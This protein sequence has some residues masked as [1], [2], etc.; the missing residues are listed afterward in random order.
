MGSILKRLSPVA[1]TGVGSLPF[2]RPGDAVQHAVAAYELPFC[3]QLPH[4]YGDMLQE[5]LGADPGRCGWSPDRDRQLPAAWDAFIL[6]VACRPPAHGLVKLQVTGPVTLAAALERGG[7]GGRSDLWTLAGEISTWLAAAVSDQV[8]GLHELGLTALVV[9][10][11]PGLMAAAGL[12]DASVAV[13]DALRAAAPAWGLHVCGEVPWEVV[14]AAEPDV[15]SYDVARYGCGRPAQVVIR[16]LLRREG[17][18]MWGAA[19]PGADHDGAAIA[20]RVRAAARAVAGEPDRIESVWQGSLLSGSCGT[21]A[22]DVHAECRLARALQVTAATL[23][24]RP[25]PARE[26]EAPP[27]AV[28]VS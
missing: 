19:E 26:P 5:W 27:A 16:R 15:I 20:D 17:R 12:R 10:D 21:G 1:T 3:P 8:A 14:D 6:A 9:V 7:A 23:R 4:A 11:E 2:T 18:V 25:V 13:W 24:G 22:I 28:N